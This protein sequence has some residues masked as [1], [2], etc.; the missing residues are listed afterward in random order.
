[1]D[2]SQLVNLNMN[3]SD[4]E[5]LDSVMGA[6]G[7]FDGDV[8]L[9]SKLNGEEADEIDSGSTIAPMVPLLC[10]IG[11]EQL[12]AGSGRF[13]TITTYE[14]FIAEWIALF[15]EARWCC[16]FAKDRI[17]K[18]TA[19]FI[20]PK[21]FWRCFAPLFDMEP[22]GL[23]LKDAGSDVLRLEYEDEFLFQNLPTKAVDCRPGVY[24]PKDECHLALDVAVV[25]PRGSNAR[26]I[27]VVLQTK[28]AICG[29]ASTH[30]VDNLI[31]DYHGSIT[32][33]KA[34]GWLPG[35][36]A[37]FLGVVYGAIDAAELERFTNACPHG[38][39]LYGEGLE[40][41]M[42]PTVYAYLKHYRTLTAEI[43]K[44]A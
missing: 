34:A 36:D 26:P 24:L 11:S 13:K 20:S 15:T 18:A 14:V 6:T 38:R 8:Q 21:Q 12:K 10:A 30:M 9:Y 7:I 22:F 37:V 25:L 28:F 35:T 32:Q 33:M 42:G 17:V 27:L 16:L 40:A 41:A 43:V 31:A 29:H 4:Y 19:R 23:L 3:R 2:R 39:L 44:V 1:M 5:S